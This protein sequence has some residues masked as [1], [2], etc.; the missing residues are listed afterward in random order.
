MAVGV[1]IDSRDP[2]MAVREAHGFLVAEMENPGCGD[3]LDLAMADDEDFAPRVA[4]R[5]LFK[6][7]NDSVLEISVTLSSVLS[8]SIGIRK[9]SFERSRFFL[10]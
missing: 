2:T 4:A 8:I 5:K 7:R 1:A 9:I 3:P 10:F 6:G